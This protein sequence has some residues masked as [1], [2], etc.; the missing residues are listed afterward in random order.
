MLLYFF[1]QWHHPSQGPRNRYT[2]C[3]GDSNGQQ[4]NSWLRSR[5]ISL[6][7][8]QRLEVTVEYF[9]TNC[10]SSFT[11]CNESL[12]AYVWESNTSVL[13]DKIPHPISSFGS[14]RL[15]AIINRPPNNPTVLTIPLEVKSKFI[16]LGFRDQGGC[17]TLFSVKISYNVCPVETLKDNLVSLPRTSSPFSSME[18]I[19]VN[20]SCATDSVQAVQGSMSVLCESSGEWNTSSLEGK[21]FC[22]E[23]ME[24]AGGI[25]K[26]IHFF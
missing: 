16:V 19:P 25:C 26:G 3:Y 22:K 17:R 2:L 4:P 1:H 18:S 14:Y 20:G 9:L 23:N 13:S 5:I 6:G 21:C 11:F 12:F 8:I 24:N 10:P 7:D 15:F